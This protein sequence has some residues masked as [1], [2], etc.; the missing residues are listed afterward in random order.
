MDSDLAIK[1]RFIC[2]VESVVEGVANISFYNE[3]VGDHEMWDAEC[4]FSRLEQYGI[5]DGDEFVY[6]VISNDRGEASIRFI[7]LDPKRISKERINNILKEV[8]NINI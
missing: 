4:K 5:S 3:S 6:E 7:R 8:S 2:R 1:A